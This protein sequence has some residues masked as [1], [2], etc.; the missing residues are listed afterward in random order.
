MAG[1][2]TWLKISKTAHDCLDPIYL[3][4]LGCGFTN[5]SLSCRRLDLSMSILYCDQYKIFLQLLSNQKF[6][7]FADDPLSGLDSLSSYM[8]VETFQRLV[9]NGFTIFCTLDQ[10]S[11][12]VY[13]LFNKYVLGIRDLLYYQALRSVKKPCFRGR[14]YIIQAFLPTK[15]RF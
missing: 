12:D 7:L 15:K 5:P 11:S 8:L 1:F 14:R 10:P 2:C 3:Q 4:H 9:K 6:I 13:A